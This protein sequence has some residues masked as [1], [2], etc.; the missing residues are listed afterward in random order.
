MSFAGDTK[1]DL[2]AIFVKKPCCRR[3]LLLGLL[4][5]SY[6]FAEREIRFTTR[7]FAAAELTV[8]LLA[9]CFDIRYPVPFLRRQN[10]EYVYAVANVSVP[11][12]K[13]HNRI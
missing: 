10:E 2:C 9:E 4:R 13:S 11:A 8:S 12:T 3:A 7:N 6:L 1:N 5:A